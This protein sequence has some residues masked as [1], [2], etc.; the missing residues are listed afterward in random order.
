MFESLT[1]TNFQSHRKTKID[2]DSGINVIYGLSQAGKTAIL[3]ALRL[4]IYNRPSGAKYFSNFITQKGQTQ[5]KLF[6]DGKSVMITKSIKR[7]KEGT[8]VLE[9]TEYGFDGQTFSPGTDVPM[10]IRDFLNISEINIQ[11]Q[12][13]V[14]FLALSSPGEIARTINRITKL[15][16]VDS[17]KSDLMKQVNEAKHEIKMLL[18]QAKEIESELIKYK[19]FED[20]ELLIRRL[21]EIDVEYTK[22]T[23]MANSIDN[24]LVKIED[25]DVEIRKAVPLVDDLQGLVEKINRAETDLQLLIQQ[26]RSIDR[27]NVLD[28]DI[29]RLRLLCDSIDRLIMMQEV[30]QSAKDLSKQIYTIRDIDI[31][32][33]DLSII[34][35]DLED[36]LQYQQTIDD[37]NC[38]E[39]RLN[40]IQDIIDMMDQDQDKRKKYRE[41]Y[42]ALLRSEK[43]CPTCLGE[44]DDKIIKKIEKEL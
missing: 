30:T 17:W 4:V 37:R 28:Q 3:R 1:I 41:R 18:D 8:K 14:P 20:F 39:R 35:A 15:E 10:E 6:L 38:L 2:F 26:K 32:I 9:G 22:N 36:L 44:I 43:I 19:G 25:I 34:Q 24:C 27:V 40:Q 23:S 31:K 12:F 42:I 5:I 16:K 11:N 29:N 33:N 13:D 21:Q 7:T